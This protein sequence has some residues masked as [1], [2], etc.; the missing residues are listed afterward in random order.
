[1]MATFICTDRLRFGMTIVRSRFFDRRKCERILLIRAVADGAGFGVAGGPILG[2]KG[3]A[4][5]SRTRRGKFQANFRFA[6]AHR[7]EEGHVT[8]LLFL[9]AFVLEKKCAAT[10]DA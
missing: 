9:G 7:S 3:D 6:A 4:P 2:R 8:F 10:G 5:E 1:M